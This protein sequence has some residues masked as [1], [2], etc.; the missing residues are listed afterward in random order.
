MESLEE[1]LKIWDMCENQSLHILYLTMSTWI[2]LFL[3]FF[4]LKFLYTTLKYNLHLTVILSIF[5]LR[6]TLSNNSEKNSIM[7]FLLD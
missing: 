4:Q 3:S 6:I 5:L 7:R 2:S 1:S